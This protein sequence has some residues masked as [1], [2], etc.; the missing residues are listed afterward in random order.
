MRNSYLRKEQAMSER[1]CRICGKKFY[2]NHPSKCT[3]SEKCSLTNARLRNKEYYS[4]T[5]YKALK[6]ERYT[7]SYQR[8]IRY[9]HICGDELPDGRQKF[10]LT[11]LFKEFLY[12]DHL[13]AYR[14]LKL[15]GYNCAEIREEISKLGL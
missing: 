12:G 9:C 3:C 8:R 1:I 14:R 13:R 4:R 5:A 15:R 7:K 2:S 10:C 11:C 6:H